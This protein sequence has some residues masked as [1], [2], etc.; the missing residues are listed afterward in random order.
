MQR[1]RR[2]PRALPVLPRPHPR[3]H[4]LPAGQADLG[5]RPRDGNPEES[6]VKLASNENPLGMSARARCRDRRDR[7]GL[8]LS[9]RQRV[10]AQEGLVRTLR[11]QAQGFVIGNGSNDILE[12][13]S[14]AFLAPGCRRCIRVT[15]SRSIRSPPT[16]AAARHRGGG[17]ELRP[18]PRRHGGGDR[19]QTRVIFIANPNNPTGTF[20]PGAELEAFLAGPAPRAGGARRGLHRIPRPEQRYD[21]IAWLARFPT[22]WCRAPSPRPTGPAGLR[23]G[24]GIAHPRWPT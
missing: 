1:S 19:P 14:Q 20:V 24:Y 22:C 4:G 15:P 7:R 18:R 12:L 11:R 16:R 9:G 17:E 10:R 21:S 5:A 13:A 3:D 23:V 2:R 6:I 8:A